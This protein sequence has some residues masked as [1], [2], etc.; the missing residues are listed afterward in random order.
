[1]ETNNRTAGSTVRSSSVAHWDSFFNWV[2][3]NEKKGIKVVFKAAQHLGFPGQPLQ[4]I[5]QGD[6]G[7][8]VAWVTMIG[9]TGPSGVLPQHYTKTL[10][11][12]AKS[13]DTAMA[14]FYD[15]FNN[16][17]IHLFYQSWKK[18]RLGVLARNI[19]PHRDQFSK[20]VFGLSGLDLKQ[21][22][23]ITH[24]FS[25]FFANKK[26]TVG[27]LKN[28]MSSILGAEV[29]VTSFVGQWLDLPDSARGKLNS[30][31]PQGQLGQGMAI[32]KRHWD[33]NHKITVNVKQMTYESLSDV[34]PNGRHCK[35]VTD[36]VNAYVPTHISVDFNCE[37]N[38]IDHKP[39]L[40]LGAQLSRNTWL[41]TNKKTAVEA[42]FKIK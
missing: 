17:I 38:D 16:H 29:D 36:L 26:R 41:Q 25:G 24:Y 15:V 7:E 2:F 10:M 42:V 13:G 18:Y 6:N 12:R 11:E 14:D 1:M 28:M 4:K 35:H 21:D 22:I 27:H 39:R 3:V 8:L 31:S 30:F 9:L 5:E 32:G 33:V 19:N 37:V 20:T 23:N 34:L 40:G